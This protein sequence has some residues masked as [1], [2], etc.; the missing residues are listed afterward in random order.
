MINKQGS[1][2]SITLLRAIAAM[3]VCLT[4]INVLNGVNVSKY[5]ALIINNGGEGITIF[6]V[7][8]GFI[9]PYS[10]YV[11]N[12]RLD[13]FWRFLWKRSIRIDPPYWATIVLTIFVMYIPFNLKSLVLNMAYLV[14][15]FKGVSWYNHI[16]WTLSIEFQFYLLLGIF[17]PLLMRFNPYLTIACLLSAGILCIAL[18]VNMDGIIFTYLYDFV[19]GI[20]L[21]LGYIGKISRRNLLF[22][23]LAFSV[24]LM[25]GVSFKSGLIPLATSLFILFY[26]NNK[27]IPGLTFVGNISYSL[28]LTHI[29]V[30]YMVSRLLHKLIPDNNWLFICTFFSCILFAY[31]FYLLVERP[32][33]RISKT[34][35][36]SGSNAPAAALVPGAASDQ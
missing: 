10:L 34:I 24:Y 15:F 30:C 20:I 4:H 23:L 26:K 19:I 1:I 5:V 33:L 7:I 36:L 29:A 31:V 3:L 32:S 27:P 16:F 2:S 9:I 17:Y 8:S 25:I 22:I 35:K 14:P 6:F 11:K 12:Y 18:N 28:Y 21:F 13:G